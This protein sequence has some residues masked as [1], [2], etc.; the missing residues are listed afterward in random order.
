MTDRLGTYP[1]E[2]EVSLAVG[3]TTPMEKLIMGPLTT[4]FWVQSPADGPVWEKT[5]LSLVLPARTFGATLDMFNLDCF[6]CWWQS[7]EEW[8]VSELF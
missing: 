8:A 3:V 7:Q 1:A 6:L 5:I 2:E 4:S